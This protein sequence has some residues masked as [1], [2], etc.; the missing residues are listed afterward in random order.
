VTATT[1]GREP[2]QVIEIDQ[3]LCVNTY[4]IA[5]CTAAVG[6]TG[7]DKC[8]NTRFTCQDAANYDQTSST[9]TLRFAKPLTNLPDEAYIIPSLV[10][11]ST[12]PTVINYATNAK[13]QKAL[14]VRA[15]LTATFTDHPHTD[16]I[17]DPYRTDRS[18]EPIARSTFWAK[19]L[20]RNPYYQNYTIRVLDGY[21]GQTLAEMT[22]RTYLIDQITGP[23]GN[24]RVTIKAKDILTLADDK[25]A[26]APPATPGELIEDEL[27]AETTLRITGAVAADYPVSPGL[28]RINDE[29]ISYT[30]VSTISPTEINLTGCTRGT[31]G[32]EAADHSLGDRVQWCIDVNA[33][34]C[35]DVAASLLLNYANVPSAYIPIT[36]WNAERDQ[37]LSL[38]D[39]STILSEPTGVTELLGELC[40]QSVMNIWWD[41]RDQEIKLRAVRPLTDTPVLLTDDANIIAESTSLM[42]EPKERASQVWVFFNQ[43]NPVEP[44]DE[45]KNYRNVYI[46]ADLDTE[47][48]EQYGTSSIKRIYSRWLSTNGQALNAA[49]RILSRLKFTPEY[50]TLTLDAKDRTLW[51]GDVVDVENRN[52]VDAW[53]APR[54]Q[55]YQIISAEEID[56]GHMVKY[57]MVRFDFDGIFSF[58]MAGGSPNFTSATDE[59]K[60]TGCFIA[61]A[62]GLMSD[63]S[64][65]YLIQ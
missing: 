11:V 46:T 12:S 15:T 13:D 64:E 53:G 34:N 32:T 29:I 38:I 59:Q 4:G 43:R 24:G 22:S 35:V 51:T 25:K 17:V 60:A 19:W 57:K 6:T 61:G 23:D 30:A 16:R 2:I 63:D 52:I 49:G 8:F 41:E 28:V 55:R 14:G 3:P 58:I 27:A 45:E 39:V 36:D 9:V 5:P 47:T 37:W 56:S 50:L 7:S 20:R 54:T 1:V 44:L 31:N 40:E 42:R 33:S 10:S 48:A 65:G 62:D 26:L 21:V 18:Y